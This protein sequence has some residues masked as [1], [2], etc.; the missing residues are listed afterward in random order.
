MC[1]ETRA[2]MFSNARLFLL[3]ERASMLF[4]H[5]FLFVFECAFIV[6]ERAFVCVFGRACICLFQR[7]LI[8]F[9]FVLNARLFCW[10]AHFCFERAFFFL[11]NA[12]LLFFERALSYL[13]FEHAFLF[14]ERAFCL[15]ARLLRC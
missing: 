10:S 2:F 7:A 8:R 4:E 1:L 12:R 14:V 15:N 9:L 13:V 3:F 5:A 6:F 11:V